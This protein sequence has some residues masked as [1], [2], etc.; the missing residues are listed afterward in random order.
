MSRRIAATTAAAV[1]CLLPAAIASQAS[2]RPA[3]RVS[4]SHA[5]A[6]PADPVADGI[7]PCPDTNLVPTAANTARIVRSTLCLI[8]AQRRQFGLVPLVEDT[9]LDRA[10]QQHSDDM[11]ARGYFDH[12]SPSGST[13]ES[14]MTAAGYLSAN[15]GYEVGEN[16]AWG[17]LNLATPAS[18]VSA[19]MNSPDH[20]ANILR[21]AF[22]QTGIGV[23]AA[24]PGGM[25]AGQPGA[26]Y[27]QDFGVITGA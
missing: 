3:H 4:K 1:A 8:N 16:I 21:A 11:V 5:I 14:R 6:R 27:T 10:A 22:R 19:W 15:V 7:G 13:P 12:V 23:T 25:G 2:A 20:R 26:T 24:V 18:V 17:T 9:R